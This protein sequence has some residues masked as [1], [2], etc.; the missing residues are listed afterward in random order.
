MNKMCSKCKENKS[1][2]EFFRVHAGSEKLRSWCKI[3][4]NK[5]RRIHYSI[6]PIPIRDQARSKGRKLRLDVLEAYGGKCICCD[7]TESQ[8]LAIDH[9]DGSGYARRFI[10][11][12]G[13]KLYLWLK[14]HNFPKDNF[15]L[16]C[17]NCNFAKGAY[18]ICP[19]QR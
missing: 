16:L 19:H 9:K 18:G 12:H 4:N 14:K 15:Q 17:H 1:S 13:R 2:E 10:E 7:I 3:C 5:Y 8:F 11:G 6:N